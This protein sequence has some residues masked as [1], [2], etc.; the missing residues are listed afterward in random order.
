LLIENWPSRSVDVP[1]FVPETSTDAPGRHIPS[2]EEVTTPLIPIF[3][4]CK[5]KKGPHQD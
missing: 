2:S 1:I 5:E 4:A 3:W